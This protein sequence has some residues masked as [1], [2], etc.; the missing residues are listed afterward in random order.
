MPI[1]GWVPLIREYI[2]VL[3]KASSIGEEYNDIRMLDELLDDQSIELIS[4]WLI[5]L[6]DRQ[7][8]EIVAF[9]IIGSHN[10]NFRSMIMDGEV[11]VVVPGLDAGVAYLDFF[12]LMG[13]TNWVDDLEELRELL[14]K[15][16][17]FRRWLGRLIRYAL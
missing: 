2:Y 15:Q 1:E 10:Q 11:T 9:L 4:K 17:K 5:G 16:S 6:S 14:P 12:L 8:Q 3:A 7:K 13:L